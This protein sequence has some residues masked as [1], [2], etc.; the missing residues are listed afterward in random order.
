MIKKI[1]S[2]I[3]RLLSLIRRKEYRLF[4]AD[5]TLEHKRFM[6]KK[7]KDQEILTKFANSLKEEMFSPIYI[8]CTNLQLGSILSSCLHNLNFITTIAQGG[9]KINITDSIENVT[10]KSIYI[11]NDEN[12]LISASQKKPLFIW[13][14]D[15][16]LLKKANHLFNIRQIFYINTQ[17]ETDCIFYVSR[18]L[19]HYDLISF[20][21]FYNSNIDYNPFV[22][23]NALCLTLPEYNQRYEYAN[24]LVQNT[25][26]KAFNFKLFI[27]LRH[28]IGWAGCGYSYKFLFKKAIQYNVDYMIIFEDDIVPVKDFDLKLQEIKEYALKNKL[29][30]DIISG[31]IT[32]IDSDT[33]LTS[34]IPLNNIDLYTTNKLYGALFN[35]YNNTIFAPLAKWTPNYET[36]LQI[37]AYINH[38]NANIL[39]SYPFIVT[40][41]Q[42]LDS[43]VWSHSNK[44]LY[45]KAISRTINKLQK[46]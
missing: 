20:E 22:N 8:N 17:N 40:Q 35:L 14:L 46:L 34:R 28:Y 27:G 15:L 19:L 30:W 39:F 36:K 33:R 10:N 25:A 31:F 21:T 4:F 24:K 42:D 2:H 44:L 6:Y 38:I 41:N 9:H 37:D 13:I 16:A 26:I 43:A 23:S 11:I 1:I 29:K 3:L 18:F 32:R 5:L 7:K 12:N 45:D